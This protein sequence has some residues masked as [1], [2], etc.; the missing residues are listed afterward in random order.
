[1]AI[2]AVIW[3]LDWTFKNNLHLLQIT[4][5]LQGMS[6]MNIPQI[7]ISNLSKVDLKKA[8]KK[9]QWNN[10]FIYTQWK[11]KYHY[12]KPESRALIPAV[13]ILFARNVS[14]NE[15]LFCGD[16][17]DDFKMAQSYGEIRFAAIVGEILKDRWVE[18]TTP[19]KITSTN[20]LST[21]PMIIEDV[22]LLPDII[23]E[24]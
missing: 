22:T 13:S 24:I 10:F 16:G 5:A 21:L 8:L 23:K 9:N 1:M 6:A 20:D 17:Y 3:G 14:R 19:K 18:I 7:I 4:N 15:I 11:E 2:K 12:C